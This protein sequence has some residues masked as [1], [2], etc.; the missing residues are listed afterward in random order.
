MAAMVS[1]KALF[2]LLA[3]MNRNNKD[4]AIGNDIME[5]MRQLKGLD[6]TLQDLFNT[7]ITSGLEIDRLKQE[8]SRLKKGEGAGQAPGAPA[9]P[10][11]PQPKP[12]P[13]SGVSIEGVVWHSG[14]G[15]KK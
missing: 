7:K 5:L 3:K 14:G 2:D 9:A 15:D 11:P 12:R 10:P 13:A 4:R 6:K 1:T 8:I